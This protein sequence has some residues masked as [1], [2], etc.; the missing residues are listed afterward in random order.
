MHQAVLKARLNNPSLLRASKAIRSWSYGLRPKRSVSALSLIDNGYLLVPDLF[1]E[2]AANAVISEYGFSERSFK[3]AAGNL[4]WPCLSTHLVKLLNDARYQTLLQTY[5]RVMYGAPPVLQTI[6]SLVV[7]YPSIA[8]EEFDSRRHGF[9][10]AWHTD[11]P[12]EFTVHL[13]LTDIT[14]STSHTAYV[15]G[16]AKGFRLYRKSRPQTLAGKEFLGFAKSGDALFFDVCGIHRANLRPG[17][18]AMIQ[19]KYTLGNDMLLFNK[20]NKKYW[21]NLVR[22]KRHSTIMTNVA[23]IFT[24]Q[25]RQIQEGDLPPGHEIILEGAHQLRDAFSSV[26]YS[27]E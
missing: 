21:S 6:P 23:E 16:S 25:V 7:S 8:P 13:P 19:I 11:Y 14:E 18:R 12:G 22:L 9:P 26:A 5:F 17:L 2:S 4:T 24:D 1:G 15:S 20:H 27:E 3:R 10:A